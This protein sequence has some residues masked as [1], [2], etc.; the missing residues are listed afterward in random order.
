[1][2]VSSRSTNACFIFKGSKSP[3]PNGLKGTNPVPNA[4][5]VEDEP[6]VPSAF[7]GQRG[8]VLS[9]SGKRSERR[10]GPVERSESG[11]RPAS[12][13]YNVTSVAHP[14]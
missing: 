6:L 10:L 2:A 11:V 1:V 8:D 9:S 3:V 5:S 4:K 12:G 7:I 13:Y 14:W